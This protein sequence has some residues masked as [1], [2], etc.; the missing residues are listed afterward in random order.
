MRARIANSRAGSCGELAIFALYGNVRSRGRIP[1]ESTVWPCRRVLTH[2]LK[3]ILSY[4]CSQPNE[5]REKSLRF[6]HD[7]AC[8]S[9]LLRAR[10]AGSGHDLTWRSCNYV[11]RVD[12]ASIDVTCARVEASDERVR[13]TEGF[14][15]ARSFP[16]TRNRYTCIA[17][18]N[19]FHRK[20][21]AYGISSPRGLTVESLTWRSLVSFDLAFQFPS[22][23]TADSFIVANI[24]LPTYWMVY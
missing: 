14:D 7:L 22:K 21:R 17:I 1:W 16:E 12:N 18:N 19:L 8:F 6:L 10:R 23:K 3:A 9:R 11:F 2:L 4:H 24:S 20:K 13:H 5:S 15:E